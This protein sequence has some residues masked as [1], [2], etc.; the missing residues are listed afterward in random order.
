[1]ETIP[2]EKVIEIG[3]QAGVRE[4]LDRISREKEERRK[5]RYDRRLR[6]TKLL[7]KNYRNFQVHCS[8]S[9]SSLGRYRT[10]AIDILDE[11]DYGDQDS[12][13]YIESIKASNERTAII[14]A[15]IENMIRIFRYICERSCKPE[16]VRRYKVIAG[17]YVDE[18]E[19]SAAQLAGELICDPRTVYR[20]RDEAVKV[21][22]ALI[23]GIDGLKMEV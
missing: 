3:V 10:N 5:G 2:L 12:E 23:F 15:H 18:E 21:L 13:F 11:L 20:D 6:N 9:I 1:M 8:D 7:L 4:A 17:L 22:S 19:K 16:E 14:I